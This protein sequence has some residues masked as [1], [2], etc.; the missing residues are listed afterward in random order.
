[1]MTGMLLVFY[2][3]D[4]GWRWGEALASKGSLLSLAVLS[5][6]VLVLFDPLFVAVPAL[7]SLA[8]GVLLRQRI[9]LIVLVVAV[10]V[11]IECLYA[12]GQQYWSMVR[13]A[14]GAVAVSTPA[15]TATAVGAAAGAAH[16]DD[17]DAA[18][19]AAPE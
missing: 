6:V 10:A 2:C 12:P 11:G 18:A 5:G 13:L 14:R 19:F 4:R 8:V 15:T 16:Q 1:M 17:D 3:F 7:T 9:P